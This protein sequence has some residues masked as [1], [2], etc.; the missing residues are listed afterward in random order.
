MTPV[1]R[2]IRAA[3]RQLW[4][5]ETKT[6]TRRAG[7]PA[8]H[9]AMADLILGPDRPT[10]RLAAAATPGGTGRCANASI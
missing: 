4:E 3:E 8:F 2:A 7:E 5:A 6:Y 10:D 1:M 9:A